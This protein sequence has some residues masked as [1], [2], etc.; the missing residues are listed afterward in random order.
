MSNPHG[1]PRRPDL[2]ALGAALSDASGLT[3]DELAAL[4]DEVLQV[5]GALAN[6]PASTDP[7]RT[8]A[9]E[10]LEAAGHLINDLRR[11]MHGDAATPGTVPGNSE[12]HWVR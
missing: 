9:F 8:R 7:A 10:V 4:A 3:D 2:R 6:L 11:E 5:T 12:P 1:I